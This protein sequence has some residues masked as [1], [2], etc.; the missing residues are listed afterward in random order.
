MDFRVMTSENR[1]LSVSSLPVF[2]LQWLACTKGPDVEG[3]LSL[4]GS[5]SGV[6]CSLFLC[7]LRKAGHKLLGTVVGQGHVP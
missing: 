1:A 6:W 4:A 2:R 3:N 5:L 7:D